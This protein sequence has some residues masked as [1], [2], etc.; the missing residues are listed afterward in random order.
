M[1][2]PTVL[3]AICM[4]FFYGHSQ[5]V[6]L[7]ADLRQHALTQ[8]NASLFNPTF[9]LDRNNPQSVSFWTRWQWQNFDADPTTLFLNYTRSLNEQSA[10]GL[11]FFL[12]NTGIY[13][14]TGAAA[15]YAYEVRFNRLIKVSF[16]ANIFG[17][18]Q[19]IADTRFPINPIP[20]IPQTAPTDDFILQV[21]PGFNISV[22]NF[23]MSLASE[24][25]FDY[26]FTDK[27]A[28][29]ATSDKIFMGMA[30]YDFP[31]MASDSTAYL[32]PSIYLRTIPE[33][34]NQ[35][36]MNALFST[37]KYWAQAGYNNFYGISVGAGGTVFNRFSLGALVEFGTS[38]S[39]NSKDPSFEIVA[40]YF[41]GKP[42]N[43]R[44]IVASGIDDL[45]QEVI[46]A[47]EELT[48]E[49]MREELRKAEE[50]A[51]GMVSGDKKEVVAESVKE[52]VTL[53]VSKEEV[54]EA[55]LDKKELK[56]LANEQKELEKQQRK[57]S[58]ATVKQEKE[59]LALNQKL[60]EE[61]AKI[62]AAE[63]KEAERAA[64]SLEKEQTKIAETKAKEE[65][66]AAAL[67]AEEKAKEEKRLA[68]LKKE[69]DAKALAE[70]DRI[71]QQRKLDA[72]EKAKL[73]NEATKAKEESARIAQ[74]EA[75]KVANDEAAAKAKEEADKVA[76]EESARLAREEAA[77]VAKAAE[78]R[79]AKEEVVTE[80]VKPQAGEKYEEVANEDGLEPGYY[81]IANVFG[82]KKYFDAFM[83]DLTKKGM[84]PKSFFRSVNK[85]NYAY[86]AKYNTISEARRARDSKFDGKYAGKTWIFR[87]VGK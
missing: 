80:E 71:E 15:N 84:Q 77:R 29:T 85:Y 34:E 28:N 58:I 40:S 59:A 70:A 44:K 83:G 6:S 8:Y 57:D 78:A 63:A 36:G 17:F 9:S 24:N 66:K 19:Q 33:Q 61:Q 47:N 68:D 56:R 10:A 64:A 16:G 30:S 87:V 42:M 67:A 86:L 54:V 38:A 39:L 26:N 82:T 25:L 11:G 65:E 73:A 76:S 69:G 32:R 37:Q 62:A 48:I 7:P 51:N 31:V 23:S 79:V 1:I 74:A 43:R 20:G 21:A 12:H 35:I 4:V 49:E 60:E 18:Q 27:G 5:D 3:I 55:Q 46:L 75:I 14:N 72:I 81:L 22:E 41:L 52:E 45:N 53:D 13:F 2:K 50:E